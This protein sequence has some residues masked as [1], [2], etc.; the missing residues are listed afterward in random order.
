MRMTFDWPLWLLSSVKLCYFMLC[1]LGVVVDMSLKFSKQCIE[2]KNRANRVLGYI[3]R[4]VSY[5]SKEV[6]LKLYNSYVR[7]HL[8]YCIQAWSPH[9]RHDINL[10]ESVQRR[11]TKI[12]PSL[13]HLEYEDR[14]RVLNMFSFER[15]CVRG[16][17]IELFKIF[18]GMDKLDF[19]KLFELEGSNRTRGHHLK[20]KKQRCRLDVRK[21]FFTNRVVDYWNSLPPETV[22]SPNLNVFKRRLDDYMGMEG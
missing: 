14:L 18:S 8:E 19:S 16:D 15:R 21:Y 2:A 1:D 9:F 7:P 4:N 17:M 20:I 5:K 13:K 22:D 12:I 3:K 11:A 10:L 6:I